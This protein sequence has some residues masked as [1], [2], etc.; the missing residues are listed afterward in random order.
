MYNSYVYDDND[1]ISWLKYR[2]SIML[3]C[4]NKHP[5]QRP[6]FTDLRD[7]FDNLLLADHK[8]DYIEFSFDTVQASNHDGSGRDG[9]LNISPVSKRYSHTSSGQEECAMLLSSEK[10]PIDT[11]SPLT[12]DNVG[13]GSPRF[14]PRQQSPQQLSLRQC[15][16][17]NRLFPSSQSICNNQEASAKSSPRRQLSP[18][19]LLP[20]RGSRESLSPQPFHATNPIAVEEHTEEQ[21]QQQRHR[22]MSMLL[23]RERDR[24]RRRGDISDR[25][26]KEPTK[27][28]GLGNKSD[29]GDACELTVLSQNVSASPSPV[30]RRRGS[31]GTLNMNS[32]GYVSFIGVDSRDLRANLPSQDIRI[33]VTGDL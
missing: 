31:E 5:R 9:F 20:R 10:L 7:K 29:N 16:P 30:V 17:S 12:L 21:E 27:L 24:V 13:N 1:I 11:P 28:A 33:T 23:S 2:Y 14:S 32:D 6:T 4:W 15:S 3:S 25:Y 8:G 19:K 26:V 18:L 22:P